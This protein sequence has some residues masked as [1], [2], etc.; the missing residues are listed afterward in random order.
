MQAEIA[1]VSRYGGNLSLIMF[2]YDN[3]KSINDTHGHEA[4]DLILQYGTSLLLEV[5][6]QEDTF[7]RWGARSSCSSSLVTAGRG[8]F[9]A[10]KG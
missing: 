8:V 7:G 6:R 4:G 5:L 10:Q 3:F 2:D 9:A 1:R